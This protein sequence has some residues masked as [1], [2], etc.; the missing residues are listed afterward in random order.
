MHVGASRRVDER[1]DDVRRRSEL[2]VAAPEVDQRRA[3]GGCGGSYAAEQ[4]DEVLRRKPLEAGGPG[5][6]PVIVCAVRPSR[7]GS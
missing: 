5:A 7:L 3:V 1:L 2:W 4:R 6:H